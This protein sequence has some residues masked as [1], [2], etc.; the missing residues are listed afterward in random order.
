MI[1][2]GCKVAQLFAGIESV[3]TDI[4]GLKTEEQFF[5]TLQDII[6]TRG[7][8]TKLI[9]DHTQVEISNKSHDILQYLF[10]QDWQS[11]SYHQHQSPAEEGYQ[12]IKRTA[13]RWMDHT[14]TPPSL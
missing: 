10:L 9:S 7:A 14:G 4:Y 12:D 1:N 3:V 2:N 6:P 8:P 13:N 5:N 11:E